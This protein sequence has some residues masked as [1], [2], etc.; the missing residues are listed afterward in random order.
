MMKPQGLTPSPIGEVQADLGGRQVTFRFGGRELVH[1]QQAFPGEPVWD[2]LS[3]VLGDGDFDGLF[4]VIAIVSRRSW[5]EVTPE[6][7]ADAMDKV[8]LEYLAA[9]LMLAAE[10]AFPKQ[11]A[12]AAEGE[13]PNS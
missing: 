8:G 9:T 13:S 1:I 6:L 5:P 3:R 12:A 2:V 10:A 4:K 11:A 7:V